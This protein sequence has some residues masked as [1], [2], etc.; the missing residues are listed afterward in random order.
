MIE[1]EKV[2]FYIN[3]TCNL[4]CENC[5]RF[6]NHN[7]VGWQRFADHEADLEKWAKYITIKQVV[8]MGG[9]PLL[10]PSLIDWIEG[11]NRIFGR[12]IQILSNGTRL[13]K[14]KKLY[15]LL[16]Q[17]HGNWLGISWHN[18]NHKDMLL[19]QID[20][21][22]THPIRYPKNINDELKTND[23]LTFIDAK[24]VKITVWVQDN[25]ISAAVHK[26]EE[27]RFTLYNNDPEEAHDDC[28]F[29]KYKSYHMINS[30][31]YKCGPVAL[32]PDFDKQH[33]LAISDSDRHL[34]NSY[35]PL[36]VDEF[37]TRGKEF[38]ENIDNVIPQCKFCPSWRNSS[39]EIIYPEVKVKSKLA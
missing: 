3:H 6:N 22:M 9:E 23:Q 14:T 25:F 35:K 1:I 8:I 24:A 2:E 37:E 31:L 39:H 13:A 16:G 12:N 36:C 28:V 38:L 15:P 10:N 34:V 17:K 5:N 26:D 11:L 27:G 18:R 4:T 30:K 20:S 21:F 33:N 19:E 7:F 32:F 29:V